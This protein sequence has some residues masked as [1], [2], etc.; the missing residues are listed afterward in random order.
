ML[1][2]EQVRKDKSRCAGRWMAVVMSNERLKVKGL[3]GKE[4]ESWREDGRAATR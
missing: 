2:D 1:G 3:G 4:E